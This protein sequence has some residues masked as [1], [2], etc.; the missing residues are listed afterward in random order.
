MS[1]EIASLPH[2]QA[3][4][5]LEGGAPV[6]LAVNPVEY[7]GPHLP[8]NTDHLLSMGMIRKLH[9]LLGQVRGL[10]ADGPALIASPLHVGVDPTPG[11]GSVF[12]PYSTVRDLVIDNCRSL[13]AMGAR[14]VILMTFHGAPLHSLAIDEGVRYLRREG[15]QAFSAFNVVLRA[16]LEYRPENHAEA[17]GEIQD[18]AARAEITARLSSD[19]HAGFWETS[20][21]LHLNPDCVADCYRELPP[22]PPYAPQAAFQRMASVA[23]RAGAE[24]LARECEFVAMGLGWMKLDPFPGYTGWPHLASSEAGAAFADDIARRYA[25]T[26][27]RVLVDGA[28]DPRPILQWLG[29][30]TLKGRISA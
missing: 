19:F 18:E 2:G 26:A 4:R 3:R 13:V 15:V 23:R 22:C 27:K 17:L 1:I 7:H 25:E 12:V 21:M 14:R 30:L 20:L 16:M 9:P 28:D 11:P 8:L 24:S 6:Y 29:T 5:T 10:A